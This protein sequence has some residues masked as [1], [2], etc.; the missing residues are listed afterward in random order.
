M[1]DLCIYR[2]NVGAFFWLI[3]LA[4]VSLKADKLWHKKTANQ[5]LL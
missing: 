3:K 1:K 2:S 4:A 5:Q